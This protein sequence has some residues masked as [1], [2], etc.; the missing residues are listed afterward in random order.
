[1][2]TVETKVQ[3]SRTLAAVGGLLALVSGAGLLAPAQQ[4]FVGMAPPTREVAVARQMKKNKAFEK[5]P[6]YRELNAKT[7]AEL[8]SVI[9]DSRKAILM[10]RMDVWR[11]RAPLKKVKYTAQYSIAA[12][13]TLLNARAGS[14]D[15]EAE[16]EPMW[17]GGDSE[18]AKN[19]WAYR[20]H[21]H[22]KRF[23]A[24]GLAGRQHIP[25][26]HA[27][28]IKR[29][30]EE[31]KKRQVAAKAFAEVPA[32]TTKEGLFAGAFAAAAVLVAGRR[33]F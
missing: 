7:D 23:P 1:M 9:A 14:G 20:A 11:K 33:R 16:E 31:T 13:K 21:G 3:M 25:L 22:Q 5:A 27:K 28:A 17:V 2:R 4:G 18:T 26:Q 24:S 8:H 10:H 6:I 15:D 29:N 19:M 32:T 30:M 12:A